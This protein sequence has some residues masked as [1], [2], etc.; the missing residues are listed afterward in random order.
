MTDND[1]QKK[2]DK[3]N[4]W[5]NNNRDKKY[6]S[7]KA[8]AE[9]RKTTAIHMPTKSAE[10]LNDYLI[11]KAEAERETIA[12][13]PEGERTAYRRKYTSKD[14]RTSLNSLIL[15]LLSEEVGQDLSP[16]VEEYKKPG[17]KKKEI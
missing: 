10:I 13:L 11:K 5:A 4:E 2:R 8:W 9:S 3:Y 16:K 7:H 6:E 14:G 12:A 1:I 15:Y 17:R